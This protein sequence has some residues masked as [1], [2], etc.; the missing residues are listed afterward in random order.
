[1]LMVD[2]S[3]VSSVYVKVPLSFTSSGTPYYANGVSVAGS[4]KLLEIDRENYKWADT[5]GVMKINSHNSI[6][7]QRAGCGSSAMTVGSYEYI[8]CTVNIKI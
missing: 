4:S 2:E 7:Q 3:Y 1:M 8:Q 5:S 6:N